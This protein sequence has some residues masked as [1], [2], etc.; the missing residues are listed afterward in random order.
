M[1]VDLVDDRIDDGSG[2]PAADMSE[3]QGIGRDTLRQASV[4]TEIRNLMA[5]SGDRLLAHDPVW[6]AASKA[7]RGD[8]PDEEPVALV[9]RRGGRIAG[10]VPF[11]RS[12]CLLRFAIGELTLYRRTM[13]DCLRLVHEAVLGGVP[14][15][16]H[17]DAICRLFAD[18][19]RA[20]PRL[21]ILLEGVPVDSALCAASVEDRRLVVRLGPPYQHQF[22]E[23]PPS[24]A[25]YERRLGRRSRHSLRYSQKKL[26]E[27]LD[28]AIEIRRFSDPAEVAGFLAAARAVSQKTYQWNLLKL[29]LRDAAALTAQLTLAAEHGWLRSYILYCGTDPTAFMLGYQYRGVYHYIDVG[30][31]PAW[32]KW[33][34]GSILQIE[35][36]KD[37]LGAADPPDRID[38]STGYGHHKARFSNRSRQEVNLL[39]LPPGWRS[40]ALA[41]AY[42]IGCAI[43]RRATALADALGVKAKLK[44]WLRRT[45]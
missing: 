42:R 3:W 28:G 38:F 7:S 36:I 20:W 5:L 8:A 16:E 13:P 25:E 33:S 22:A 18:L 19:A 14:P 37:L 9:L 11:C 24:F 43:D 23:L 12:R 21:P 31:D 2:S 40:H 30:Y 6:H 27:Q 15:A 10:Y 39:L 44:R 26:S 34:V 41:G 1:L 17:A 29:G 4:T 35:M 32:A 45:I